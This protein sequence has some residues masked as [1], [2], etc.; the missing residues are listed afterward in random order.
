MRKLRNEQ[1][2][3][4]VITLFEVEDALVNG[5]RRTR[6]K[7]LNKL[8]DVTDLLNCTLPVKDQL[9]FV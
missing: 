9:H 2:Q 7:V 8:H 6:A 3:E 1:I 5:D 4:V